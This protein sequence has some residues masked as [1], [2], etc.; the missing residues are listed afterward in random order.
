MAR[1]WMNITLASALLFAA[2]ARADE[3]SALLARYKAVSGGAAWDSLE[4]M[5]ATGTLATGGLS[6][7]VA[8]VQD[9]TDGRS[10]SRYKLGPIEGANGYDGTHSWS[11]DPGGEVAALDTP[12]ANRRARSQAW[13]DSLGFWYPA[14]IRAGYGSVADREADGR[15]YRVVEATPDGGD[16]L[17]LWFDPSSG[18]LARTIQREGQ[19]TVTTVTDDYREVGGVR[20]AYHIVSDRTDAAG[21]TDPR[22]HTEIRLASIRLNDAVADADFAMPEMAATARIDNP[23]G[24]ARV[25]FDLVNNHIYADGAIDGKPARFLVDTGGMNLLTPAAAKTFG[26]AGEGKLAGRGVGDEVVDFSFGHADEVRLGDAA[27]AKPVFV[28]MDLGELAKVE[29]V[30]FD[31]LVGYEMFRRF[32][33]TIDYAGGTLTLVDAAKF[34]PPA[35]A[36]MIPF[37]LDDRIPIVEGTLDGVPARMSIDTGSRSSLTMHSPFVR[38]HRLVEKYHAASD[39]VIGWGV[40]GPSRGRVA[41][42]GTLVLGDLKIPG[43]AGDLYTGDKGAFANPDLA[44]NLGGGLFKRFTVA[45]DYAKKRLY[46]APNANH[47]K[48]DAFD[49]SGFFLLGADDALVVADVA[50]ESAGAKAG[51]AAQDR[52]VAIDGRAVSWKSLVEWRAKLRDLPVGTKLEV[53]RVRGGKKETVELVLAD[54]VPAAFH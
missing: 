47:A 15:H 8:V 5:H 30:E 22:N 38:E 43:I 1:I 6:G 46:F 29:G 25:H 37:E 11:R 17:T 26:I 48:A 12:E 19:D 54:R 33:V 10:A 16:T 3:A 27:L 18:L 21:R 49:R 52:I 2:G 32:G 40:G 23:G 34:A 7:E 44:G 9:V 13:L 28:I 31:G 53:D 24:I 41:R 45:F 35:G 4:T 42:F 51:F 20:M 39:A 14:R 50:A 36:S